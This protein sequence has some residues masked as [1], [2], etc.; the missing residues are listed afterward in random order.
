MRGWTRALLL[1]ALACVAAGACA[2]GGEIAAPEAEGPAM[3]G[4]T[5]TSSEPPPTTP[6]DTTGRWGG[7][8]G[9]GG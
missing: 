8:G 6:P 5:T 2:R 1:A 3:D 4:G 7:F 9:S